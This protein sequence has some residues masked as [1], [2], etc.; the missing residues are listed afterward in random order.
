MFALMVVP[1]MQLFDGIF[2]TEYCRDAF[3]FLVGFNSFRS[4][5]FVLILV[6]FWYQVLDFKCNFGEHCYKDLYFVFITCTLP[7]EF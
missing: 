5:C 4:S 1:V 3:S 2:N 7:R 6:L